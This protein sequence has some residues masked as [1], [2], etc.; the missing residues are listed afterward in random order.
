MGNE[1]T[2]DIAGI[3]L[4]VLQSQAKLFA[5]Y[6]RIDQEGIRTGFNK[7]SITVRTAG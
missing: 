7:K 5:A 3:F 2:L 6:A 1:N 4:D